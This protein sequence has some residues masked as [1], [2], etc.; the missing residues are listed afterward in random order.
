MFTQTLA[1][2]PGSHSTR[3]SYRSVLYRYCYCSNVLLSRL[4]SFVACRQPN[5]FQMWMCRNF[6]DIPQVSGTASWSK[7]LKRHSA[8]HYSPRSILLPWSEK[9][10]PFLFGCSLQLILFTY[11]RYYDLLE[12]A[13]DASESE[14]KKAYRKKSVFFHSL[15]LSLSLSFLRAL[16]LHPDKGGDPELFKEVTH[17]Y[18][19][20]RP[21]F[22]VC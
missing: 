9:R 19:H 14:L 21:T 15:A 18:V 3:S 16:R 11:R 12:V 20:A 17:A 8:V 5:D 6:Q 1:G 10:Q 13:P 7:R 2:D 22:F 4:V